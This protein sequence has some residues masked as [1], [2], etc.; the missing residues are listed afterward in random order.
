MLKDEIIDRLHDTRAQLAKAIIALPPSATE[1]RRR[2][3]EQQ[4]AIDAAVRAVLDAAF[5]NA[6]KPELA[7]AL[8]KLDGETRKLKE[9][10]KTIETVNAVIDTTTKVVQLAS[11]IIAL[12]A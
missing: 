1:E 2:L 11:S 12:A 10:A 7:E 8:E 6:E 5:R 3:G 9:T 4:E